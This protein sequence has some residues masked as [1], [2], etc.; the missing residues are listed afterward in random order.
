MS[1][2]DQEKFIVRVYDGFDNQ[3]TDV[4]GP[5]SKDEAEAK[6]LELTDNGTHNTSYDDIDYYKVF[7]DDVRMLF[8]GGFGAHDR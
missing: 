6:W 8:S 2:E 4:T 1:D 7:P 5:L 3:C